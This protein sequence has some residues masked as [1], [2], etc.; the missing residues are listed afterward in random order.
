MEFVVDLEERILRIRKLLS[1]LGLQPDQTPAPEHSFLSGVHRQLERLGTDRVEYLA[2]FAGQLAR[3]AMVDSVLSETEERS[4]IRLLEA[5]TEL[6]QGECQLVVKLMHHEAET[7]KGKHNHLLNRAFNRHASN[8][9]KEQLI[10]SLYAVAAA[11]D[12]IS[13]EEE[14]EIRRIAAAVLLPHKTLMDIRSRYR[15]HL[16]ILDLL[17]SRTKRATKA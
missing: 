10:D 4:I 5:H 13:D 17:P 7:L 11:D 8:Q 9:D 3:V 6:S 15:E 14:Q 12:R 2:A 16:K 1:V